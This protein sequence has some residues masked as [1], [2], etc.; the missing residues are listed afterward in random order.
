MNY[1][2]S[3]FKL[4]CTKVLLTIPIGYFVFGEEHFLVV[5]CLAFVIFIDTVLGIWVSV[6]HKVFTSHKLGRIASKISKYTF[7]LASIW[8]LGCLSPVAFGWTYKFFGTFLVLTEVFSNFEKLSLLGLKLP[9]KFLARLNKNFYD[10]YFSDGEDKEN[11][12]NKI[13]NKK[14]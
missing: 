8:I 14:L 10:Y 1:F 13:L 4:L 6:K 9:T 11:A 3:T 2:L 5:Y 7:A 12:L